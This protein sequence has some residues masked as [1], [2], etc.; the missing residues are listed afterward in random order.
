[1][2]PSLGG[3][4]RIPLILDELGST[5]WKA[6][7]RAVEALVRLG[8]AALPGLIETLEHPDSDVRARAATA[9]GVIGEQGAVKPLLAGLHDP[10][11]IVR[12]ACVRALGRIGGA[13]AAEGLVGALRDDRGSVSLEA[14]WA[15][16]DMS[17]SGGL[18]QQLVHRLRGGL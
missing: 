14:R 3:T 2:E 11:D 5:S 10:S 4:S 7:R 1:M 18:L 6:R 12:E 15:L 13:E 8:A 9:L 17:D 16:R